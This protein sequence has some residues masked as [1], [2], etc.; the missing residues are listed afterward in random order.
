MYFFFF[1]FIGFCILTLSQIRL[2]EQ[3][4]LVV[5]PAGRSRKD[6][7]RLARSCFVDA[8]VLHR[9]FSSEFVNSVGGRE[10]RISNYT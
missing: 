3:C 5:E 6:L 10:D 8:N 1:F 7:N 2:A 4:F 9:L